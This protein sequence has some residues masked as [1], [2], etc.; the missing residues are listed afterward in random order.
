MGLVLRTYYAYVPAKPGFSAGSA[1][2]LL[3]L[4]L[5]ILYVYATIPSRYV[6]VSRVDTDRVGKWVWL[7]VRMRT[8]L[9]SPVSLLDQRL[10]SWHCIYR[11]YMYMRL[12][13]HDTKR[14]VAYIPIEWGKLGLILCTFI[15]Y[16][17]RS[18]LSLNGE[19]TSADTDG[20]LFFLTNGF[21]FIYCIVCF[22]CLNEFLKCWFL[23]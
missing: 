11:F 15:P 9:P 21:L 19:A 1:T 5:S 7:C 4:Y 3:V 2:N 22:V 6:E 13:Y 12:Y 16:P 14:L 20:I 18:I 23:L 8:Y 17:Y 10:T